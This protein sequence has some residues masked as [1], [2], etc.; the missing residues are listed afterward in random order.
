MPWVAVA[1]G[2]D[3]PTALP[4][5]MPTPIIADTPPRLGRGVAVGDEGGR[6]RLQGVDAEL[7][8]QPDQRRWRARSCASGSPRRK[9]A[10]S[11]AP[12]TIQG[13]R[14][15]KRERV[16]SERAP[17]SGWAKTLATKATVVTKARLP[18]LPASSM[19]ATMLGSRMPRPPELIA[20]MAT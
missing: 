6:G 17:A 11:R 16:A 13:V 5:V 15:P 2:D 10:A 7:D 19:P 4:M 14:R 3:A 20:R 8:D 9:P 18:T 1:A 12:P